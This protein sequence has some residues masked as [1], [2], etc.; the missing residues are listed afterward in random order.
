MRPHIIIRGSTS[1]SA[2]SNWRL[3][4]SRGLLG[5]LWTHSCSTDA[6]RKSWVCGMHDKAVSI[7]LSFLFVPV[8]LPHKR[9]HKIR[10]VV[11]VYEFMYVCVHLSTLCTS[12]HVYMYIQRQGCAY[13]YVKQMNFSLFEGQN[14]NTSK[15]VKDKQYFKNNKVCLYLDIYT[16][17]F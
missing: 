10:A 1:W 3:H 7:T 2:F 8:G 4:S 16:L 12:L 5:I 14:V 9:P 15:P 13:L 17:L 11:Y 6:H